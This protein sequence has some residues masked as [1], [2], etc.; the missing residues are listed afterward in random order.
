MT[1]DTHVPVVDTGLD[2]SG[3]PATRVRRSRGNW[4]IIAAAAIL[5]IIFAAGL[6]AWLNPSLDPFLIAGR[7]FQSISA[8][9]LLGTD[10]IGRDSFARLATASVTSLLISLAATIVAG[11]I[12]VTVG[13]TAAYLEG[14][15]ASVIMRFVDVGLAI[16]GI[17]LALT[18]RVILGPGT[19]T[20]I[21]SLGI[22]FAPGIAR[23]AY[24][25]AHEVRH[26]AYV[27]A[28]E[29]DNVPGVQIVLK[30][31]LPNAVTPV[32]VQL[33]ATAAAAV[34]L[35]AALSYLGQGIQPPNPSIGQMVQEYGQYIQAAPLLFTAPVIAL[36]LMSVAWNL[37]ADG[38]RRHSAAR[39]ISE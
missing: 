31:L 15:I 38:L 30:H 34:A 13:F 17:L 3:T 2:A 8:E 18:I 1:L 27:Q 24:G 25:A 20:L 23:I 10:D 36:I 4:E 33:A 28:A 7:P 5:L 14:A 26:R 29:L 12:G 32:S 21:L 37:L 9:H 6:F 22:L 39:A 16:P 19:G 11:L 35:E